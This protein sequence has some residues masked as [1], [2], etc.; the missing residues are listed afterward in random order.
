MSKL[1]TNEVKSDKEKIK[2]ATMSTSK[3]VKFIHWVLKM[4]NM[5]CLNYP[6]KRANP[7]PRFGKPPDSSYYFK[8]LLTDAIKKKLLKHLK[9]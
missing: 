7:N 5:C 8:P 9:Y 3:K 4:S 6:S 2:A 1:A